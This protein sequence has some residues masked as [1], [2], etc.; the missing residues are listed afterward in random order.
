MPKISSTLG[1]DLAIRQLIPAKSGANAQLYYLGTDVTLTQDDVPFAAVSAAGLPQSE[2]DFLVFANTVTI[3]EDLL[4]PGATIQIFAREIIAKAGTVLDVS[5]APPSKSWP[6]GIPSLQPSTLPGAPGVV[7]AD[8]GA[9]NNAGQ[10]QL[11]ADVF[12][13]GGAYGGGTTNRA[14]SLDR[15][16]QR[17]LVA[18]MSTYL[19][20]PDLNAFPVS[21]PAVGQFAPT[22]AAFGGLADLNLASSYDAGSRTFTAAGTLT[23]LAIDAVVHIAVD[24]PLKLNFDLT[25]SITSVLDDTFTPGPPTLSLALTNASAAAFPAAIQTAFQNVLPG[26]IEK[27]VNAL[28]VFATLASAIQKAILPASASSP[29]LVLLAAGGEGGRGQDGSAGNQGAKGAPGKT[30]NEISLPDIPPPPEC[31]GGPGDPGGIGGDAGKSGAAGNGGNVTV[32]GVTKAL[33]GVLVVTGLGAGGNAAVGGPGGAGGPGGDGGKYLVGY[34]SAVQWATAP[35]GPQGPAGPG[36]KFGGAPGTNGNAGVPTVG[37][38]TYDALAGFAS[39]GQLQIAQQAAKVDY[40]NAASTSDYTEVITEYNWL[41]NVTLA[42]T[43]QTKVGNLTPTDIAVRA[44]INGAVAVELARLAL[45]LDY[46]GNAANWTPVLTLG[47]YQSRVNQLVLLGTAITTQVQ[48]YESAEVAQQRDA[49]KAT[50]ASLENDL[51]N[52]TNTIGTLL[53]QIKAAEAFIIQ[54]NGEITQQQELVESLISGDEAEAAKSATGCNDVVGILSAVASIAQFGMAAAGG[55]GDLAAAQKVVASAAQA[56]KGGQSLLD[57]LFPSPADFGSL[58]GAY[59]KI[60]NLLKTNPNSALIAV[61]EDE[62]DD[63]IDGYFTQQQAADLQAQMQD[64]IDLAQTRNTTVLNTT[65]A[66]VKLADLQAQIVQKGAELAN[67]A[68][69]LAA[70]NPALPDLIAFMQRA[71][72]DT[73]NGL[74]DNLWQENQ[75]Y[76][77]WS[78]DPQP[79]TLQGL[80]LGSLSATA[81]SLSKNI[82]DYLQKTARPFSKFQGQT[83]TITAAENASAFTRLRGKKQ[84]TISIPLASGPFSSFYQITAETVAVGLLGVT[85]PAGTPANPMLLT[86]NLVQS[87]PDVL[88][89]PPP[90]LKRFTFTHDPRAVP[91]QYNYTAG[92]VTVTGEIGDTKQGFTGLSPFAM[93]KLDFDNP[94]NHWLDLSALTGVTL[95]FSGYLLGKPAQLSAEPH[96]VRPM[97]A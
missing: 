66:Y 65:A 16:L 76:S 93:W 69:L 56:M 30:E 82:E 88:A 78:L 13:V 9:G 27:V 89:S 12:T 29:S 95:T 73:M 79:F 22:K 37:S 19:G 91:F 67:V 40:M 70:Q 5:G 41:Y 84:L 68:A 24:L 87:G 44:G 85:P 42:C 34:G 21:L 11:Y 10:I 77:Y 31:I 80:N 15:A 53:Q 54:L 49:L 81:N 7:G 17:A 36:A 61:D 90:D 97:T 18:A 46:F 51:V 50:E 47:F 6:A 4:N 1:E 75:A 52:I 92:M 86:L 26:Y 55:I 48:G 23:K 14:I 3:A 96:G 57:E 2:T 32:G 72:Q 28:P 38:T 63:L 58:S 62:F 35:D 8:G 59:S 39:L 71:I 74:V 25:I 45:N 83:I 64:L 94:D 43:K 60:I 20:T 33:T